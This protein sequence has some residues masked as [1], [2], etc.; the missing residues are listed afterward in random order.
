MSKKIETFKKGIVLGSVLFFT[1]LMCFTIPNITPLVVCVL[2][3]LLM[4]W[5]ANAQNKATVIVET[6]IPII[7]NFIYS[8]VDKLNTPLAVQFFLG[9]LISPLLLLGLLLVVL[10]AIIQGLIVPLFRDR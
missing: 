1:I 2:L 6:T 4:A 7:D 8:K 10:Y 5:V 3:L 9:M